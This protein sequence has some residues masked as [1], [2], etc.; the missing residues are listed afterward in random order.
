[1]P[2]PRPSKEIMD[3]VRVLSDAIEASE[4]LRYDR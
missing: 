3:E 1:M 4:N 2:G